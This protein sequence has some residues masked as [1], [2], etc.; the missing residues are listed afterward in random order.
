[1]LTLPH[2]MVTLDANT[3]TWLISIE[4]YFNWNVMLGI[5][6]ALFARKK[7]MGLV[8]KFWQII[9]THLFQLEHLQQ[10][11]ITQLEV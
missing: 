5:E 10:L 6:C 7:L 2:M 8:R 4:K 3:F 11:S 9:A 1:M